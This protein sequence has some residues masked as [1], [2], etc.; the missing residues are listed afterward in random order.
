MDNTKFSTVINAEVK[1]WEAALKLYP[2]EIY[3][4]EDERGDKNEIDRDHFMKII[5]SNESEEYWRERNKPNFIN[6]LTE[7]EKYIFDALIAS[8]HVQ[9]FL[10][11]EG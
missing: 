11:G 2:I 3:E 4:S 5:R 7:R 8:R 9:D 1:L 6:E 10:W